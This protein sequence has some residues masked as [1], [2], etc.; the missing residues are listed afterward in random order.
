MDGGDLVIGELALVMEREAVGAGTPRGIAC[1]DTF[2][3]MA[4]AYATASSTEVSGIGAM[5]PT[6]WH[7]T[8]S[9]WSSGATSWW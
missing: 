8:H 4:V 9:R 1:P 7:A 3:A 6:V 2:S 5:P